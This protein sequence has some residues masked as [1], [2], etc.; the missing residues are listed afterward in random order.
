M[1]TF[2]ILTGGLVAIVICTLAGMI[3]FGTGNPPPP[4]ASMNGPFEKVDFSDLPTVQTIPSNNGSPI[5]F[6]EWKNASTGEPELTLILIHGSSGSSTSLHPLARALSAEGIFVYAP[7]IRGHGH[8]GRKGDIDYA[9]QLDDD[10]RTL[11]ADVKARQPRSRLVLAGFS[12]GGGFALHAAALPLGKSFERAVLISPMLGVRAPTVGPSGNAWA[13]PF[14]PRILALLVL[15]RIGI[16]AFDHLPAL[17][18]AIPPE[19]AD[20]LTGEYSWRLLRAFYTADY[21]ADLKM[22]PMPIHVLVGEKDELFSAERFEPT[23]HAARPHAKVTVVPALNHTEMTT[24]PRAVPALVAAVR[25]G[26]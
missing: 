19:R 7:D 17:A 1:K 11:L 13:K 5:A 16:H 12:A 21:F 18:F 25:G 23:I 24:D 8:T 3:A 22:A 2:F 26:A 4:L 10:F 15:N 20:I 9:E 6:R 14:I